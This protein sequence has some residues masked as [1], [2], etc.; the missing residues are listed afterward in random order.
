MSEQIDKCNRIMEYALSSEV[1]SYAKKQLEKNLIKY[2]RSNDKK[3]A[4]LTFKIDGKGFSSLL[5]AIYYVEDWNELEIDFYHP[6]TH[7]I[8]EYDTPTKLIKITKPGRGAL[9]IYHINPFALNQWN[10][11]QEPLVEPAMFRGYAASF[12]SPESIKTHSNKV[13]E[14]PLVPPRPMCTPFE[15]W[16][17][18]RFKGI[19][20]FQLNLCA[21]SQKR[22]YLYRI[23]I[24]NSTLLM[25]F[26]NGKIPIANRVFRDPFD[27]YHL[28][29]FFS[30]HDLPDL[31]AKV[32][33]VIFE[34]ENADA[35]DIEIGLGI[36]EKMARDNMQ[37][38]EKRKL[39]EAIG[40]PPKTR[41]FINLEMIK[42]IASKIK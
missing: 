27:Y 20:P 24:L 18:I 12:Y 38:L 36:T 35:A 4:D 13:D 39:I 21:Y 29:N 40:K 10:P 34:L 1:D 2:E 9:M 30:T 23:D 11:K 33:E 6:N 17:D 5:D 3:L 14:R 32:L 26:R 19:V 25:D 15:F 16:E 22:R 8:W 28:D 31:A 42:K 37:A 7:E 41:Y